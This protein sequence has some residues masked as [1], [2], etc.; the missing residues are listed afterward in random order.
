MVTLSPGM[1]VVPVLALAA[2]LLLYVYFPQRAPDKRRFTRF[3]GWVTGLSF[4][5][6]FAWEVSH[7]R[8]YQVFGR[9]DVPHVAFLAGA[10]LADAIMAVLL[11]FGFA[12]LYHD[13]LWVQRLSPF[14]TGWLMVAG[15]SG[16]MI[17]ELAH[18]SAGN[19]AYT[20]RMP[21]LPGLGVGVSPV[22]QF[23][24]LPTLIF[25]LSRYF[26]RPTGG[27]SSRKAGLT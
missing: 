9:Y 12:L 26:T 25:G 3:I 7:C 6:N 22:L 4:L 27:N 5:V 24:V 8:L 2:G 19:W 14:R 18:L 1:L 21:L 17:S 13:G 15:G 11:Y 10:A 23:T 20:D 16:A